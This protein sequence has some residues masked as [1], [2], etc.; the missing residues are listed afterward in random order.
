M[1]I[2]VDADAVIQVVV[3]VLLTGRQQHGSSP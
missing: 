1:A 2:W 3:K